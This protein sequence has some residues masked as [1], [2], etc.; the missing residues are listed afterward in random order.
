MPIDLDEFERLER[1]PRLWKAPWR[2]HTFEIDCPC[3]NGDDCGDTHYCCEVEA[4]DEYPDS[5]CVVQISV[6]GL[7]TFAEPTAAFI[8]FAR[9]NAAAIIAELRAARELCAR[10]DD[11]MNCEAGWPGVDR[12][13]ALVK[14]IAVCQRI[15]EGGE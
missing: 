6:P 13:N 4:P 9:N 14:A 8:A 10:A 3:P 2:A 7:E 15:V 1:D 12:L 11:Y 5:Q